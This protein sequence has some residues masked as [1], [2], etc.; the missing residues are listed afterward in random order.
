MK[1]EL[2]QLVY[3][4]EH[5]KMH[6][7]KILARMQVDNL[8]PDWNS[9]VEQKST[10]TPFG[11]AGIFYATCHGIYPESRIYASRKEAAESL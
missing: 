3:Y 1:F 4:I 9:T 10:F 11:V 5:N 8:H 2:D 7:A 6:S